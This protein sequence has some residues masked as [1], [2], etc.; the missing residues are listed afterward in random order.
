MISLDKQVLLDLHGQLSKV[1]GGD[2]ALRAEKLLDG[3]LATVEK[4]QSTNGDLAT[5]AAALAY[6][7]TLARAFVE[8]NTRLAAAAAELFV[9]LNDGQ[10]V[11]DDTE[12][13]S[14][15]DRIAAGNLSQRAVE[16]AFAGW[17][18]AP[19]A[20]SGQAAPQVSKGPKQSKDSS[21]RKDTLHDSSGAAATSG[22]TA[23]A[24]QEGTDGE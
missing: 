9:L 10:L 11:A 23:D 17:V 12:L 22:E 5:C 6:R 24:I 15:F 16:R 1:F 8:G 7:L 4:S 21:P 2:P 3:A 14:L 19:P 20:S 13:A 18:K